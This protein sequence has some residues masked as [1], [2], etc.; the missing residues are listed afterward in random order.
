MYYTHDKLPSSS[1]S[2]AGRRHVS[3][4]LCLPFLSLVI[5]RA[6][7]LTGTRYLMWSKQRT[8]ASPLLLPPPS[9]PVSNST[10]PH[11][12]L[13]RLRRHAFS[14]R[15]SSRRLWFPQLKPSRHGVCCIQHC[16]LSWIEATALPLAPH[17]FSPCQPVSLRESVVLTRT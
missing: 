11:E 13:L 15:D 9:S 7:R 17:A 16:S 3:N 5:Q 2:S 14:L 10:P 12:V 1:M 6:S 4:Y 8:S